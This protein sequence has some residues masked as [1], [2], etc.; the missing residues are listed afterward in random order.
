[1][2]VSASLYV[3]HLADIISGEACLG[4]AMEVRQSTS[5]NARTALRLCY[6]RA[7][8]SPQ[9]SWV[10][11]TPKTAT[12]AHTVTWTNSVRIILGLDPGQ[13]ILGFS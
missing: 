1:M 3:I 2:I 9:R 11:A 5:K 7:A 13:N 10:A 6:E 8:Y 12:N 4:L